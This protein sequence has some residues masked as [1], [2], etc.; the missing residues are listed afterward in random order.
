[1]TPNPQQPE[2]RRSGTDSSS[3]NEPKVATEAK[4]MPSGK[5]QGTDKG[6]KGGGKGG[7]VPPSQQPGWV[8][9]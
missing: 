1:M 7:G 3:P 2:Q 4:D 8:Q 5:P 6:N 9:R